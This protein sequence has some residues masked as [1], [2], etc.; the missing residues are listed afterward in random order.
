MNKV[1]TNKYLL[2]YAIKKFIKSLPFLL[3]LLLLP[4]PEWGY[5]SYPSSNFV[6]SSV[7]K[8]LLPLP[9][10]LLLLLQRSLSLLLLLLLSLLFG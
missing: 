1:K 8:I 6:L 9:V 3:V 2:F 5:C 7:L 4:P 10:L